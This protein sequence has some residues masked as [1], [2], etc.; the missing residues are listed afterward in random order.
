MH[1]KYRKNVKFNFQ[2]NM[3]YIRRG[4]VVSNY[5]YSAINL[6]LNQ[7]IYAS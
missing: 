1:H 4:N 3:T 5:L 2:N 7:P 6:T